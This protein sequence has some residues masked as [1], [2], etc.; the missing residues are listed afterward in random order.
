M[1]RLFHQLMLMVGLLMV[2]L[3]AV[4]EPASAARKTFD[5]GKDKIQTFQEQTSY[6]IEFRLLQSTGGGP[7]EQIDGGRLCFATSVNDGSQCVNSV[8]QVITAKP[9]QGGSQGTLTFEYGIGFNTPDDGRHLVAFFNEARINEGDTE[10]ILVPALTRAG[11][12]TALETWSET[13]F[14]PDPETRLRLQARL[15]KSSTQ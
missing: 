6:S 14:I 4:I 11:T 7:F 8:G 3:L 1:F 5:I 10:S 9:T 15:V 13:L 2:G 12:V